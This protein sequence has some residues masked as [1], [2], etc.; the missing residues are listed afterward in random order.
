MLLFVIFTKDLASS[1]CSLSACL[2]FK[3]KVVSEQGKDGVV[4]LLSTVKTREIE[5]MNSL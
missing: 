3:A 2:K 5:S 4:P 1:V